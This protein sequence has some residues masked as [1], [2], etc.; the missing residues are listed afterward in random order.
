MVYDIVI[1]CHSCHVAGFA[2]GIGFKSLIAAFQKK[3][4]YDM[5]GRDEKRC[6]LL[7]GQIQNEHLRV[8]NMFSC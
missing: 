2:G 7:K 4:V 5:A 8:T 3:A 1:F 6:E